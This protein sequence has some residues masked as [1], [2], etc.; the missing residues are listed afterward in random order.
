MNNIN[1]VSSIL[2][3]LS[4][5]TTQSRPDPAEKF[6]ELDADSSGGLDKTELS[7]MAKELSKMTG[8]T[9]NVD[10]SITIYDTD[11]DGQLNKDEMN[12]MMQKMGPPTASGAGMQQVMGAYQTNSGDDEISTLMKM[13]DDLDQIL[14]SS[15]TD[16]STS[17]SSE[18]TMSILLKALD[19]MASASSDF[20]SRP[21]S[22]TKFKELDSDSSGG[23]SKSE[24]DVMA[25][26]IA[27]MTGETIDT[28]D[29]LNSYDTDKDGELS[30]AEMDTMMQEKMAQAGSPP[31]PPGGSSPASTAASSD[32]D[33]VT[34]LRRLME[35]YAA[36]LKTES[37]SNL[38]SLI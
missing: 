13:L 7:A 22:E 37:N 29:A 25:K 3:S 20:V 34:L 28:E 36:N 2:G 6:K 32:S 38:D 9:L 1:G 14:S 12:T 30:K 17:T 21:D 4:V 15:T 10:E 11:N 26:E 27:S 16:S 5:Q 23:L 19:K 24:L 8:K 33:Q 31:P 18:D 35:Q